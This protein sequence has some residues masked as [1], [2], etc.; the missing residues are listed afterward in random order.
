MTLTNG[1]K[2]VTMAVCFECVSLHISFLGDDAII[3]ANILYAFD[4]VL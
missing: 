3:I 4:R 2:I 1:R